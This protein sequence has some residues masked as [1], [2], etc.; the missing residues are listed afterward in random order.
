MK[1]NRFAY[2]EV[3][4][5]LLCNYTSIIINDE[6]KSVFYSFAFWTYSLVIKNAIEVFQ[7]FFVLARY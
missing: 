1:P 6:E 5:A 7:T 3:V 2:T 4:I